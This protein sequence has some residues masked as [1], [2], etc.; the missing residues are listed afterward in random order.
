MGKPTRECVRGLE[1]ASEAVSVV[2]EQSSR[3]VEDNVTCANTLQL[4]V[5]TPVSQIL[6]QPF[7]PD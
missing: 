6:S 4:K 3:S 2:F 5:Q 1:L 7:C